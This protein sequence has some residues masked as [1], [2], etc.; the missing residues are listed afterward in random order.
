MNKD[1]ISE[2]TKS[3]EYAV[4]GAVAIRAMELEREMERQGQK[5]SLM[6]LN[7]GNPQILGQKPITFNREVLAACLHDDMDKNRII[8]SKDACDRAEFY[9]NSIKHRAIGAYT[10][11]PGL[12]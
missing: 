7:I 5:M 11:S 8:F 6:Q 9:L 1:T 10:D 12:R 2:R 4:R 3:F